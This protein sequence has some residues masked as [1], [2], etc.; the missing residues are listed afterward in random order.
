MQSIVAQFLSGLMQ[1]MFLFLLAVGLSLIFGV[2]RIINISHGAFFTL[3]A[4][5]LLTVNAD[6][7]LS[8]PAFFGLVIFG[9]VAI[10]ALGAIFE[11][12]ILRRAYR[13]GMLIVALVTFG[14]LLVVEEVVRI[15]WG[16]DMKATARPRG[17]SGAITAGGVD[18][19]IYSL[20]IIAVGLLM[21]LSV[22]LVV[23]KTRFGLLIR[24]ASIDRQMLA[25][26]GVNVQRVF[27]LTYAAGTCLAGIAGIMAAPL[28]SIL[29]TM[30]SSIIIE[31]FAVVVIGGLGSLP[32]SLL[33][34]IIVGQ[35]QAFGILLAPQSTLF[36]LY[37]LMTVILIVRPRGLLGS[38]TD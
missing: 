20:V 22:W 16:A 18:F 33:G 17:F 6:G 15:I 37:L 4:Y 21:A 28:V 1:A 32:G 12:L 14:S 24:G 30:G 3:G 8:I 10:G 26:L 23:E 25:V 19:P 29:P 13:G 36:V 35:C 7:A 27:T 2:S 5:L 38:R 11:M 9:G 31:A 34:A